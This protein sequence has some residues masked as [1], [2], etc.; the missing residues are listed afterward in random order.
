MD[1]MEQVTRGFWR[2]SPGSVYPLL[3]EMA[4]EGVLRRNPD[5]RYALT[6][7]AR[8]QAGWPFGGFGPRNAQDA[9]REI[10]GLVAY[11]EDL[12]TSQAKEFEAAKP[13]LKNAAQRLDKLAA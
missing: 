8:S 12:R 2:P 13:S 10:S 1:E 9:V 7:T 5:G 3:E 6:E 11:L 4:T